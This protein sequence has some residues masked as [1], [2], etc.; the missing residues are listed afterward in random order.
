M[1]DIMVAS[2]CPRRA[3]LSRDAGIHKVAVLRSVAKEVV[4]AVIAN[5]FI[6][7]KA[8]IT[9]L[10]K[11]GI[12]T[13]K[14]NMLDF[15]VKA[16]VDRMAQ[17]IDAYATFERTHGKHKVVATEFEWGIPFGTDATGK[18]RE[19]HC[20]VNLLIDRGD[21][22]ESVRYVYK[23]NPYYARGTVRRT[24]SEEDRFVEN[25]AELLLLQRAGEAEAKK[26][27]YDITKTPVFGSIYYLRLKKKFAGVV[28][29]VIPFEGTDGA[30]IASYFFTKGESDDIISKY[31]TVHADINH[32]CCD[33]AYCKTCMYDELCHM[34][35][36]KRSLTV[37]PDEV[38]VPINDI[39]MTDAQRNFVEFREGECR[40]NAVAGSGKTT[41]IVLRT[42][43][44]LEEGVDPRHILMM[45]F[46]DKAAAEMKDRLKAY[47]SGSMLKGE[48]L[49]VDSVQVATFNSWGQSV[50]DN[51]FGELG[52]TKKPELIDDVVKKDIIIGILKDHQTLPL[53]YNNPFMAS[54]THQGAVIK[55]LELI[56]AMKAAHVKTET[57][58]LEIV[59]G[60]SS[61]MGPR[62]AEL[63]E[64][65][66]RYNAKLVA[67]NLLDYEDQLRLLL[68][69][70]KL[71]IF[72]KMPYAHVIV[73]EFQD[74][75]PN[76]IDIIRR[77]VA[78][79]PNYKSMAV[80]GDVMQSIYSFRNAT[81]ENLAEFGKYFPDMV[82]IS[83]QDNFRSFTP[84]VKMANNLIEKES[85]IK[86][87][88]VA[89][90]LGHGLDP[91]LRE[92]NEKDQEITLFVNQTKKLIRD[93]TDPAN[94]AVLCR[95]RGELVNMR[96]A[97]AAA[98][99]PVIMRV[100]EIV[101]D[102]PYVKAIIA[103]A[104]FLLTG[105]KISLSLY[106]KSLGLNPFDTA[107]IDKLGTE[108]TDKMNAAVSE[109][110]KRTLFDNLVEDAC[111]DFMAATFMEGVKNKRF[112]SLNRMLTYIVKYQQY[113]TKEMHSTALEK[114]NSVTLITV[115]SAKGLEWPVVLLST[116]GFRTKFG[117]MA[118]EERRLLYV[119]VTRAKEK[120][121]VTY[122]KKQE[123]LV[124]LLR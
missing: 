111:E 63:L 36:S 48:A 39:H 88:I 28:T 113:G 52:F 50:L 46:T 109:K 101:G 55:M 30:N 41:I 106:A 107:M 84:I 11:E 33:S 77:M 12:K 78:Q 61:T 71:G 42:I 102:A 13:R 118:S 8:N 123:S 7:D 81:P 68:D 10:I 22:L 75:N 90:K 103:L 110:S 80:V 31:Q 37:L 124:S 97:M 73:D 43:G 87:T 25:S 117:A 45:T 85:D 47:A 9:K 24:R 119:A 98:G 56:D 23:E 96:D 115:H 105:D 14:H 60:P 116:K 27:G 121:L 99:I 5:D 92:I 62:A 82:D 83:M 6:A 94:I 58:V 72:A 3:A 1:A 15:E 76:Q 108:I 29:E 93:G 26:R 95:T 104:K 122:T 38:P 18:P 69:L 114:S 79:L 64:I 120:L 20:H 89:H 34:E 65:Y 74:S 16:E 70:D 100:P 2:K 35:F 67:E 49:D 57:E 44:L 51:Y 21:A 54:F 66:E 19:K 32:P 59:G 4:L 112:R 53:D 91:V 86:A 17:C 40:V